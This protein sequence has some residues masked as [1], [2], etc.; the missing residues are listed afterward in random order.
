[1]EW[2]TKKTLASRSSPHA[3]QEIL[4]VEAG[5]GIERPEGLVHE[6]DAG[7]K[8]ESARDGHPLSHPARKLVRVLVL[9]AFDVEAHLVDPLAGL[10]RGGLLFRRLDTRARRRRCRARCG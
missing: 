6:D 8:D 2:V 5:A 1:M 10:C 7:R 9:I 3:Y 4:H